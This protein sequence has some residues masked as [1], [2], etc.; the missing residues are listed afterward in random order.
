MDKILKGLIVSDQGRLRECVQAFL[1]SIPQID[2]VQFSENLDEAIKV[3]A[4]EE[5]DFAFIYMNMP[6]FGLQDLVRT[7]K[8]KSPDTKALVIAENTVQAQLVR[9]AGAD[10]VVIQGASAEQY[11]E[12][13]YSIIPS[14]DLK[15]KI[16]LCTK[17]QPEN[18]THTTV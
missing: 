7:L 8:A 3:I 15:E 18:S 10:G 14:E 9:V 17:A 16:E 11:M 12:A 5:I 6:D 13:L 1:V 4:S 2:S